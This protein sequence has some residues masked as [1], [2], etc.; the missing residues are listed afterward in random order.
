[1]ESDFDLLDAKAILELQAELGISEAI[2]EKPINRFKK[3]ADE[4]PSVATL[5]PDATSVNIELQSPIDEAVLISANAKNLLELKTAIENFPHCDLKRGARNVV[6]SAGSSAAKIMIIG[7][8]PGREEDFQGVPFVGRAGQLLD[9]MLFSI[10]LNR[11]ESDFEKS[12]YITN[13]IPWRPPENR[14]PTQDEIDMMLPFLKRHIELV[15]PKVIV[16]MGNVSCQSL[17]GRRGI[18]KLRGVWAEAF[19]LPVLPMLHPAY[20]LRNPVAKREA[21]SDLLSLK[22][23]VYL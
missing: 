4:K 16:A 3:N 19:G 23:K 21:W 1:M 13:V 17:L 2:S 6:F 22:E 15:E 11:E 9:K 18:T 20:L 14:E 8:A 10:G 5:N 12:V 7:E